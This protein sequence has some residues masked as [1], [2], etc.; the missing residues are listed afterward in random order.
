M[1]LDIITSYPGKIKLAEIPYV[2]NDQDLGSII[3]VKAVDKAGNERLV[4]YIPPLTD[5]EAA[6]Q[7]DYRQLTIYIV[8]IV[9]IISS[10][11]VIIL[12]YLTK[13]IS[14]RRKK[15]EEEQTN[16]DD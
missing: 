8:A 10:I 13:R 11:G 3:R 1:L 7:H 12:V 2:L 15:Y 6:K 9:I 5:V 4:E 14:S 16:M